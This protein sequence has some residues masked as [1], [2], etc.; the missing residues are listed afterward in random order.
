MQHEQRGWWIQCLGAGLCF[1]NQWQTVEVFRKPVWKQSGVDFNI[2]LSGIN[3][4]SRILVCFTFSVHSVKEQRMSTAILRTVAQF[5]WTSAEADSM[6]SLK[7]ERKSIIFKDKAELCCSCLALRLRLFSIAANKPL[8][9]Q[10]TAA[11]RSPCTGQS[12]SS[13]C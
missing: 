10:D 9:R 11:V 6:E 12:L 2:T 8:R 13:G 3:R 7:P 4:Q 5:L 1:F